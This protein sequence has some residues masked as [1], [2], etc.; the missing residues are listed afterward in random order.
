VAKQAAEPASAIP[1]ASAPNRNSPP[2]ARQM[3]GQVAVLTM[4][5]RS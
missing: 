3:D 2:V 4:E 5:R 1:V